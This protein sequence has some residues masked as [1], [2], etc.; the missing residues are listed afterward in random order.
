MGRLSVADGLVMCLLIADKEPERFGHAAARWHGRFAL[1]ARAIDLRGSELALAAVAGL[2]SHAS[3]AA[4]A[5]ALG[6]LCR[7]HKIDS[8][9]MTLERYLGGERLGGARGTQ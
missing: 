6:E 4:A 5:A 3:R 2:P 7:V 1:E 8:A 9:R